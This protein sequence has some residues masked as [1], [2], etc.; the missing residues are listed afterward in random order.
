MSRPLFPRRIAFALAAGSLLPLPA[1]AQGPAFP[2]RNPRYIVPFPPGGLT[3]IMARLV[4]QKL[5]EGWGRPVVVDNRAGGNAM[6]GADLAAKAEPD[7]HT[8]LAITL[9]HAVNATL[10]PN[11]PYDFRRAFVPI[12]V[13]GSLPLAVVVNTQAM[14]TGDL[15]ALVARARQRS[16]NVGSSGTG[17]P[18]HLGLELFRRVSRAGDNIV[19]VPYRGGAPAVTDLAGGSLDMMVSNLPECLA[20]IRGGRLR[21][22]AVT[23]AERHPLV[24]DVPTVR[25]AGLPELEITNWTA[26]ITQAA[27]PAALRARLERD[28]LAAIH[29]AT[30]TR[31]A[32]EG[33][34]QVLGW[35]SARSAAFIRAETDRWATLVTEAGIKPDA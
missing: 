11:A 3:D 34:F 28:V 17:S 26:V 9:T 24:P 29:D 12:S 32:S 21:A 4:A 14:P 6:I 19:H 27:V 22:L 15:A 20:Q 7:G 16:L 23:S 5:G 10:F 25:E 1:P 30:T 33:G 18:P 2:E 31:R 8:L 35:D 13:L